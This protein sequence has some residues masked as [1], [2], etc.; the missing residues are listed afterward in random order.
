M[1]QRH[2]TQSASTRSWQ[3]LS[4]VYAGERQ[5][6]QGQVAIIFA[7]LLLALVGFVA[8]SIDGGYVMA[9][10]R[11]AQNAADAGA[12]AAAKS[13][14]DEQTGDI[15]TSGSSY[16]TQNA[17]AGSSAVV[18][19]P[20]ATGEY[21]GDEKYV[22]V[23]VTKNVQ[24]F[25]VGAVYDGD[26]SVSASATA[27]IEKEPADYALVTLDTSAEPGI[28]MNGN[29]GI[30]LTGGD[31]SAISNTNIQGGSNTTFTAPG[32]IDANGA[33]SSGGGWT[34]TR[35][36][37]PQIE[38]PL[39]WMSPPA[40]GTTR[41]F[42]A[43]CGSNSGC[44]IEP[45]WYRNQSTAVKRTMTM[46]PG[47]YYFEDSTLEL[48]SSGS[49]VEGANVLLYFDS[50]SVFDPKV[51]NV[52]LTYRTPTA[53]GTQAGLVFWYTNCDTIDL[54]GSGDMYFEGI[55]YAPCAH[56]QMHGNPS[57]D[58]IRG[59][60]FVGTLELKGTS[61]LGVNYF[62]H[63]DTSKPKIFLVE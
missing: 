22:Q 21:S 26:W 50:S 1:A 38:D 34:D 12:L 48:Q 39:E 27:G 60:V 58:T 35:P 33:I 47:V 24:K 44:T 53:A 43:S 3:Q 40:K 57:G 6:S 36:G 30:V 45:G 7:I 29:T 11:Q 4:E 8:L 59:Q 2:R 25:F 42:P 18:S 31:A 51:G 17:G 5:A 16:A 55:F 52:D 61:D 62:K 41:T 37:Q 19:W 49:T 23:S 15:Q 54:Q 28:Y 13:L 14:F 9:E 32:T 63:V 20:P 10:R 46:S 56:V